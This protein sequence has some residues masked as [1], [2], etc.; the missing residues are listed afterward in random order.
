MKKIEVIPHFYL[1]NPETGAKA[2]I[3]G[4]CPPGYEKRR[5]GYTW[6]CLKRNGS[7]T[8]GL[9]RKSVETKEEALEIAQRVAANLEARGCTPP[10]VIGML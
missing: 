2:S 5:W 7:I 8:I 1:I 6:H 9:S 3:Y 4:A 10:I